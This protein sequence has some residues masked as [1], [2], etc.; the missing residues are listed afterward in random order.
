MPIAK[1]VQYDYTL[2]NVILSRV[3]TGFYKKY[4]HKIFLFCKFH[5]TFLHLKSSAFCA[6]P[7]IM[8]QKPRRPPLSAKNQYFSLKNKRKYVKM[9]FGDNGSVVF[10]FYGNIHKPCREVKACGRTIF[11]TAPLTRKTTNTGV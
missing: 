10:V 1:T 9:V 4:L 5:P 2:F 11:C 7:S 6:R 3:L 8:P